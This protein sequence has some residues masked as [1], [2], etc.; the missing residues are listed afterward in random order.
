MRQP[1][2][3]GVLLALTLSASTHFDISRAQSPAPVE[4]VSSFPRH[5]R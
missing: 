5:A 3:I 2:L 4:N 1:R